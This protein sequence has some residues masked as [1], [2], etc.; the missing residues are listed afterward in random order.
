L[1]CCDG[2]PWEHKVDKR[3]FASQRT[4][5]CLPDKNHSVDHGPYTG[6][7]THGPYTPGRIPPGTSTANPAC[8]TPPHG[9]RKKPRASTKPRSAGS[10]YDDHTTRGERLG[11][12]VMPAHV[13]PDVREAFRERPAS[14]RCS[15]EVVPFP[16]SRAS[17]HVVKGNIH[18]RSHRRKRNQRGAEHESDCVDRVW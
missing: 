4:G 6:G 12:A 1:P 3:R 11:S 2:S 17:K 14:R 10:A 9:R 16:R 15:G 8:P 18:H 13:S 5:L 7:E